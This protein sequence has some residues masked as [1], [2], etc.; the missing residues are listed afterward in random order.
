MKTIILTILYTILLAVPLSADENDAALVDETEISSK[1][2]TQLLSDDL[3]E[4]EALIWYLFHCGYAIRTQSKLLIFD[5]VREHWV[6]QTPPPN[7][8]LANGWINPDEINNLDVYVFVTHSHRDHYDTTIHNW[9]RLIP[10]ITYFYGWNERSDAQSNNLAAP[11]ASFK[12]D[13]I[14]I[15][16]INSHHSGVPEVAYLIHTDGLVIY[17]GGDYTGSV[18]EDI[19]YLKQKT[20]HIDI[21]MLNDHCGDAVMLPT[22]A[23]QPKM[24]FAGHFGGEEQKLGSIMKCCRDKQLPCDVK[25]PEFRGELFRYNP[26]GR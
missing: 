8:S 2:V 26:G 12:D 3:G 17:H 16:T 6:S 24:I 7:P 15:H 13:N 23:F 21:A 9:S 20:D 11:R 1:P 22:E 19:K 5:Y 18:R 25:N 4:N 14:E 10:N